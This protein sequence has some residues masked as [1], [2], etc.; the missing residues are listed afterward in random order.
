M[1]MA[2]SSYLNDVNATCGTSYDCNFCHNSSANEQA[3]LSDGACAFCPNDSSC[4]T[5]PPPSP[6][7]TDADKDGFFAEPG[8]AQLY[9]CNDR[10]TNIYPGAREV[11]CDGVDQDCSGAD[12]LK[13]KGCRQR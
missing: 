10:N 2:R 7:C 6:T 11:P 9:D 4:T 13:G 3:Y 1:A 12:K 5:A 8:C